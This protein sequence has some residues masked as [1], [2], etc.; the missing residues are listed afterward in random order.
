[1]CQDKN[2]L[3]GEALLNQVAQNAPEEKEEGG[4]GCGGCGCGGQRD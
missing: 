1:M 2:K 4:C 3:E